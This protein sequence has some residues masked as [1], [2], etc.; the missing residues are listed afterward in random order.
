MDPETQAVAA[1]TPGPRLGEPVRLTVTC[2]GYLL[3]IES[4]VTGK[5]DDA[6]EVSCPTPLKAPASTI[7]PGKIV[8]LW[9]KHGPSE[10]AQIVAMQPGQETSIALRT[11][12]TLQGIGRCRDFARVPVHPL[13][14]MVVLGTAGHTQAIRAA[15]VDVGGGGCGIIAPRALPMDASACL[16]VRL[17]ESHEEIAVQ[18][19]VRTCTQLAHFHHAGLMFTGISHA[20]REGLIRALVTEERH[21]RTEIGLQS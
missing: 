16:R 3:K 10:R 12:S 2:Y 7:S 9:H 13:E 19:V 5:S 17:A 1:A 6:L 18:A 20:A 21:W 15:V 4:I 11:L 8:R 14:T